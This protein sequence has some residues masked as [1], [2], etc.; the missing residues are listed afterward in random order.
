GAAR[1]VG[2]GC[3]GGGQLGGGVEAHPPRVGAR[4]VGRVPLRGGLAP[5]GP[6]IAC[7]GAGLLCAR[8]AGPRGRGGGDEGGRLRAPVG[9]GG[10]RGALGRPRVGQEPVGPARVGVDRDGAALCAPAR[11]A[12]RG[13]A[14]ARGARAPGHAWVAAGLR[15]LAVL[16]ALL[17]LARLRGLLVGL[18]KRVPNAHTFGR[19]AGKKRGDA[20][21][22]QVF[23]PQDK[24]AQGLQFA[25]AL[26]GILL[27]VVHPLREVSATHGL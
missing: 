11:L 4:L 1:R 3:A 15:L 2:A 20:V 10:R 6:G 7:R 25:A 16:L 19:E 9:R 23:V 12:R 14:V 27:V 18:E 24:D 5:E 8:L 22:A 13:G 21:V 26:A 17:A